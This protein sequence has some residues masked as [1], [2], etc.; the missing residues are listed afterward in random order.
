MP[1]REI[2]EFEILRMFLVFLKAT[3]KATDRRL[4]W[5]LSPVSSYGVNLWMKVLLPVDKIGQLYVVNS[6]ITVKCG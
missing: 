6:V 5:L 2:Y 3:L 1:E 4:R